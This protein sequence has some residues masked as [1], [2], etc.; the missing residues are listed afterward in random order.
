MSKKL[1]IAALSSFFMTLLILAIFQPINAYA[2]NILPNGSYETDNDNDGVP[3]NHTKV[4]NNGTPT[5]SLDTSEKYEGG[6][7]YK[8][9]GG[10]SDDST[11]LNFQITSASEMVG[12]NYKFSVYQKT[13]NISSTT[14]TSLRFTFID[15]DNQKVIPDKYYYGSTGTT[16]WTMLEVG[17]RVPAGVATIEISEF[18]LFTSGT[19][20]WDDA[21]LAPDDNILPNSSFE[22]DANSDGVPDSYTKVINGGSPVVALDTNVYYDG[23]SSVKMTGSNNDIDRCQLYYLLNDSNVAEMAGK[24]YKISIYQKTDN[25][26]SSSYGTV[27]RVCFL[28]S[29]NVT[30][31]SNLMIQGAKG[32]TDW[33]KLQATFSVPQGTT[34]IVVEP[35]LWYASG[36]VWWDKIRLEPDSLIV[37]SGFEDDNNNNGVSD[38][39]TVITYSGNPIISKDIAVSYRGGKSQ[40]IIGESTADRAEVCQSYNVSQ[41]NGMSYNLKGFQKTSDISSSAYGTCIR[42]LF[43][44]SSGNDVISPVYIAGE[45]GNNDWTKMEYSF[46]I[47]TGTVTLYVEAFL[48][49][50]SGT[51]WWDDI[52]LQPYTE[53]LIANP[54]FETDEDNDGVPYAWTEEINGGNPT[55]TLDSNNYKSGLKSF[56][57]IGD[58]SDDR[59]NLCQLLIIPSDWSY[60]AYEFTAWVKTDN[61][62]SSGYGS[63]ARI[64]FLNSSG[65]SVGDPYYVPGPKETTDWTMLNDY[66]IIPSGTAKIRV[67]LFLWYASGNIWWD[68]VN[69][70][71]FEPVNNT[72]FEIDREKDNAPDG[73]TKYEYAGSPTMTLDTGTYYEGSKSLKVTGNSLTD[74]INVYQIVQIPSIKQNWAYKVSAYYKTQGISAVNIGTYMIINFKNSSGLD[75]GPSCKVWAGNGDHDW[76]KLE[77]VVTLPYDTTKIVIN[78]FLSSASGTIW[79]DSVKVSPVEVLNNPDLETDAD[80]NNIPDNWA[81][82]IISG[83]P[84]AAVDTNEY[85]YSGSYNYTFKSVKITGNNSN[86][87]AAFAQTVKLNGNYTSGGQ[88]SVWYKTKDIVP[89]SAYGIYAKLT[90]LDSN[91]AQIGNTLFMYGAS[92]SSLWTQMLKNF[93]PPQSAESIRIELYLDNATGTVWFDRTVLVPL[94]CTAVECPVVCNGISGVTVMDGRPTFSISGGN[95]TALYTLQY[96]QDS[97]FA[98]GTTIT[99]LTIGSYTP[100]F[101]LAEGGWY[102]RASATNTS[103]QTTSY[104]AVNKIFVH[105]LVAS[106]LKITP[107]GDEA[108]DTVS[109]SYNLQDSATVTLKILDSQSNQVRMLVNSQAQDTGLHDVIWDGKNDQGITV[110]AGTYTAKLTLTISG[111]NIDS[112]FNIEVDPNDTNAFKGLENNEDW[113][114]F[115]EDFIEKTSLYIKDDFDASTGHSLRF[116]KSS[117]DRVFSYASTALILAYSYHTATSSLYNN[118]TIRDQAISYF[119]YVLSQEIEGTGSCT[120]ALG[121]DANMDRFMLC[122]LADAYLL[123]QDDVDSTK[124][125]L[126]LNFLRRAASYQMNTYPLDT[127][128]YGKYPN[129]DAAYLYGLGLVGTIDNN[130]ALLNEASNMVDLMSDDLQPNG[131]FFYINGTNPNWGYQHVTMGL[132]ARYYEVTGDTKVPA[133][134]QN[135]V[136]YYPMTAELNGYTEYGSNPELK[137][138]WLGREYPTGPDTVAYFTNDGKN[139]M[140][141]NIIRKKY[142]LMYPSG[143][144]FVTNTYFLYCGK[145]MYSPSLNAVKLTNI[146]EGVIKDTD[147]GGFRAHWG[148]FEASLTNTKAQ[149]TLA[150]AVLFNEANVLTPVDGAVGSIYF[151]SKKGIIAGVKPKDYYYIIPPKDISDGDTA[152]Q[153]TITKQ[154]IYVSSKIGVQY[155]QFIPTSSFGF[156]YNGGGTGDWKVKQTWILFKNRLIGLNTLSCINTGDGNMARSRLIFGPSTLR[157]LT[158]QMDADDMYGNYGGM[159]FWVKKSTS[160]A[161]DFGTVS[162][163]AEPGYRNGFRSPTQAVLYM[164]NNNG[165]SIHWTSGDQISYNAVFFPLGTY[166]S[167]KAW[168]DD[169]IENN[170]AFSNP[171]TN[172]HAVQINADDGSGEYYAVIANHDNASSLS[173]N[174]TV[175]LPDGNYTLSM[176]NDDSGTPATAIDITVSAG[177]Y[178]LGYN[179]NADL[180]AVYAFIP[181]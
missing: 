102:V 87:K 65:G 179:L 22:I 5:A 125:T 90:F 15:S 99:D 84:V 32:T 138:Y 50:A 115:Y 51:V 68:N 1:L 129:Q 52:V 76:T 168:H 97:S 28:D 96:S 120:T 4:I 40:K 112:I 74:R 91:N 178:S 108:N 94:P 175:T 154:N 114:T 141:A 3:D 33:S 86:D 162:D 21:V 71:P 59:G 72:S 9:V 42:L 17:F 37:N 131:S 181:K 92:G 77:K 6:K 146:D 2:D 29:N 132:L 98:S 157:T 139:K 81:F 123:L 89:S 171:Q 127:N 117:S 55:F 124:R 158:T 62:M 30:L 130:S 78:L 82:N 107:N 176:H 152:S 20:W 24:S 145:G 148:N 25:V 34:K 137:Q 156:I 14:G 19:V 18:L 172:I 105:R 79:W 104:G 101:Q 100:A 36:V 26:V 80:S 118:T 10:S 8:M 109:L 64:E 63:V 56:N 122:S 103:N 88:F 47:P 165:N 60:S 159:G 106:P 170:I 134:L 67:R 164:K 147:I 49:Y 41:L 45:K 46:T 44:D 169:P 38:N 58:S 142:S 166:S 160:S 39:W 155:T 150:S 167:A 83:S 161:W 23:N 69:V 121:G 177:T 85:Y 13:S 11:S 75:S 144:A 73:W 136:D 7:A 149:N 53:S 35:F 110:A 57:E 140:V 135:A 70:V 128:A 93:I 143:W 119:D 61:I 16:D 126:W 173:G 151:E 163:S 133:L 111:N 116:L 54:S 180:V 153:P 12:K 43:K 48:W 174:M 113:S 31:I 66:F 27:L 95:D